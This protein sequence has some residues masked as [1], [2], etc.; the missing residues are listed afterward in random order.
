[1]ILLRL[2]LSALESNVYLRKV[3]K[4]FNDSFSNFSYVSAEKFGF[5]TLVH[6]V[7]T[8]LIIYSSLRDSTTLASPVAM[9]RAQKCGISRL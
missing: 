7:H 8:I 2:H 5:V 1:M 6:A 4:V 9:E 3:K